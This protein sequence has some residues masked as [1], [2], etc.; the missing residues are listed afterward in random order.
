[1]RCIIIKTDSAAR[2]ST[3]KEGQVSTEKPKEMINAYCR[4]I[5]VVESEDVR[6]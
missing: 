3:K 6:N 1:M 2:I 4:A 5:V